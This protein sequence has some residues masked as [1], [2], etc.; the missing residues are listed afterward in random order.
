MI[1]SNYI[2]VRVD[3]RDAPTEKAP[4]RLRDAI[5]EACYG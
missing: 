1:C 2:R 3:P 4:R 5:G